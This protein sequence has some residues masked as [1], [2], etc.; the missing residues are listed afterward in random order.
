MRFL[1]IIAVLALA[2]TGC[3]ALS[4][5]VDVQGTLVAGDSIYATTAADL[6]R[7]SV[8]SETQVAATLVAVET[9]SAAYRSVN[10]QL[11]ATL[12]AGSTPTP[13]LMVGQADPN[14]GG[15]IR[16]GA[17]DRLFIKT[18][19]SAG[20]DANG[21]VVDPTTSFSSDVTR[22]YA[23]FRAFNVAAGTPMRADWFYEND[24]RI[25][26][27]WRVPSGIGEACLWFD[28]DISRTEF[29]VGQWQVAL[30][31]DDEMFQLEDRMAFF[32]TSD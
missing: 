13:A 19:V 14:T 23:T 5:G 28:I 12:A 6:A 3:Q 27:D 8:G 17:T 31:V 11:L 18:G 20:V 2:L 10:D 30:Y 4:G 26:D 21:C 1:S 29:T 25:R 9:E 7:Q 15:E 22:L 16:F 32:I 24:L